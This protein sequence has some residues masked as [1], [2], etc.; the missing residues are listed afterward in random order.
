MKKTPQLFIAAFTAFMLVGC[1]SGDSSADATKSNVAAPAAPGAA[2]VAAT[3]NGK[4]AAD[5]A[6]GTR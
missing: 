5:A 6:D 2:P 1:G 3:P 4:A